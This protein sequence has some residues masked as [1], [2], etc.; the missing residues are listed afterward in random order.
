MSNIKEELNYC[1]MSYLF[2]SEPDPYMDED[3]GVPELDEE[4][5]PPFEYDDTP[6]ILEAPKVPPYY[7][8]DKQQMEYW[9]E[10]V[11]FNQF[12]EEISQRVIGQPNLIKVLLNVYIY[13]KNCAKGR[14]TCTNVLMAAPS[15]C[16]KTE[17]YRALRTYFRHHIPNMPVVQIDMTNI[18]QEGFKG[19]DKE[20]ITAPLKEMGS[21]GYGIIFMDEFDKKLIPSYDASGSN[22]NLHIQNQLLTLIEGINEEGFDTTYTMFIGMGSF[23]SCRQERSSRKSFGFVNNESVEAKKHYADITLEDALSVGAIP[24]MLGR[25]STIVNYHELSEQAIDKV[26]NLLAGNIEHEFDV[27]IKIGR[28]FRNYLHTQANT[29][30]GCRCIRNIIQKNVLD[31]M[32][33][34]YL[35][36]ESCENGIISIPDQ[37]KARFIK[38]KK[39]SVL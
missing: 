15:G 36:N 6:I 38:S 12:V 21:T 32:E 1:N 29:K 18:T 31:A 8:T 37:D 14:S 13:I 2:D 20:C 35:S 30:F 39:I 26:I 27:K 28:L 22:V 10:N 17:T 5:E 33:K 3:F 19:A 25:F 9:L 16:G 24:E 4:Y 23:D 7:L 11:T 34:M